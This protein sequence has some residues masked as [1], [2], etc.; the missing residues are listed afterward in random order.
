MVPGGQGEGFLFVVA[1]MSK[2]FIYDVLSLNAGDNLYGTTAPSPPGDGMVSTLVKKL[3]Q[4]GRAAV[5]SH[6]VGDR[7]DGMAITLRQGLQDRA[8]QG[9]C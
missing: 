1:Q 6:E 8:K 3:A 2:D 4:L 9:R 5:S 7:H